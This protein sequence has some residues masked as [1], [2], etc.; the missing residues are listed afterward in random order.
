MVESFLIPVFVWNVYLLSNESNIII[1]PK[2]KS[3]P[4]RHM[5]MIGMPFVPVPISLIL[6]V[7][8]S[9]AFFFCFG[10][11]H[12]LNILNLILGVSVEHSNQILKHRTKKLVVDAG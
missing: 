8:L 12:C 5:P 7:H 1:Y 9:F 10:Y 4:L 2:K 11:C 6:G 3:M